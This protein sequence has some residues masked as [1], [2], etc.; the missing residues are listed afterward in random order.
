MADKKSQK[1]SFS[2]NSNPVKKSIASVKNEPPFCP[3]LIT[4]SQLVTYDPHQITLVNPSTSRMTSL[5]KPIQQSPSFA[6]ALTNDY[7]PFAKKK[8]LPA[9]TKYVKSSPYLLIYS[10]KLFHIEFHHWNISNPLTLIKYYYPT[11]PV[12][13]AQLHFALSNP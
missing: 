5:G 13:G 9:P 1:P 7:D 3:G 11:N 2:R 4:P 10:H 6:R 12:D 8:A